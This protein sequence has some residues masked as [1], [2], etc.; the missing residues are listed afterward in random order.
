ME[1][2]RSP[3]DRGRFCAAP[4]NPLDS[5]PKRETPTALE[6]AAGD[7]KADEGHRRG[8]DYTAQRRAAIVQRRFGLS[9]ATAAAVAA[10]A[11]GAAA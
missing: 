4:Q 11:W 3:L 8:V 6:G 7:P 10:L 9:P 1:T 5:P 2:A